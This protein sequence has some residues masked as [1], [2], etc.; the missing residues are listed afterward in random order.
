MAMVTMATEPD[1]EVVG[2][3]SA[4]GGS[5][6]YDRTGDG[7]TTLDLSPRR[8]LDDV[9]GYVSRLPFGGTDCALPW[10]WALEQGKEFDTIITA[11]DNETWAGPVHV[12]QAQRR[13][14]EQTGIPAR[15]II[16]GMTATNWSVNDPTDPL[17]LDVAG[18]DSAVPNLVSDFS[19]GR[20]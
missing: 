13:Y 1:V 18:F 7:L 14:R 4:R 2:F 19:A 16:L 9:I 20:V 15:S 3:T 8:R 6:Y 5:R 10:T 17:A 11:T 12:H